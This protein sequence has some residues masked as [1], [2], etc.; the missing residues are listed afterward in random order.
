ME[1]AKLYENQRKSWR[2][3]KKHPSRSRNV[4]DRQRENINVYPRS[5]LGQLS[6]WTNAL[7]CR[8]QNR[9]RTSMIKL[10]LSILPELL[11]HL[12]ITTITIISTDNLTT[13][14]SIHRL[15]NF[16]SK[17]EQASSYSHDPYILIST[18]TKTTT[19]TQAIKA[20]YSFMT[21]CS[22][23]RLG[24]DI[25][26]HTCM[27]DDNDSVV[28][29]RRTRGSSRYADFYRCCRCSSKMSLLEFSIQAREAISFFEL[30]PWNNQEWKD[31]C[32]QNNIR[33]THRIVH[34][35]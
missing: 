28:W 14:Y 20:T 8:F 15:I 13:A 1:D 26:D 29:S 35:R 9:G 7:H 21:S 5:N 10:L 4:H 31:V 2:K 33:G 12:I 19:I 32:D 25:V 11:C 34:W 18:T 17:V 27:W 24:D 30:H 22:I 16:R 6:I 23:R 3:Y